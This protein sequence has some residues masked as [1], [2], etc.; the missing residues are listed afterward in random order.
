MKKVIS[1]M[2]SL[3]LLLSFGL[4]QAASAPAYD[5]V[6]LQLSHHNAV[7]QPIHEALTKWAAMLSEQ[8]GGAVTID[9]YP[10]AS[11]YSS[12]DAQDAVLMGTLDMCLGDTSLMSSNVPAY[13]L[14][15]LPFLINSYDTAAQIVYGEVGRQIDQ[16]MADTVGAVALGW[17]WN[18][19]RNMC[20]TKPITSVADCKGLKIRSPGADIYLDTFNTLGM[21]PNVISWSEA[22]TAMQSGIVEGVESGLEAFYTQGFYT[23][24]NNICLSRHML[25][26]IGPVISAKVWG[27]LSADTQQ[28]MKDTWAVCQAELNEK[29]IGNEDGY[30]QKLAD[31]G[32][33]ITQ[34][35]N[36]DEVVALFTDYWTQAAE[37]ASATDLLATIMGIV[38]K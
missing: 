13:A 26:I 29:V 6:T 3:A 34:F 24:G 9:I 19:F 1:L 17:T 8:S 20:T 27:G 16:I 28:L 33:N 10:A 37:K 38:N 32:C 11:L 30:Q 5:T 7:D 22:Y 18:G 15:S 21:S 25:S 35:E 2:L 23:L 14:F 12:G 4:A 36:R 31:A